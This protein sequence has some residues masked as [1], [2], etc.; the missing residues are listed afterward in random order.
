MRTGSRHESPGEAG[1]SHFIEH[2]LFKGTRKKSAKE[3]SEEI[4]LLG[5]Y[6]N[7]FT[8][9]EHTCLYA[10]VS[11]EHFEAA[12]ELMGE[13]LLEPLFDPVDIDRERQVVMEEIA[14]YE[15]NPE[16]VVHDLF[17]S[18]LWP[19][20]PLGRPVLGEPE[21][22]LGLGRDTLLDFFHRHYTPG[23]MVLSAVGRLDHG[24]VLAET[25]RILG[26]KGRVTSPWEFC[27]PAAASCQTQC[28]RD[29]EQV[30]ICMGFPTVPMEHPDVYPLLLLGEIMGGSASSRL[31]QRV[32]E[33]LGLVYSIYSSASHY[34]DGG[35]FL[36]YAG[37]SPGRWHEVRE[38]IT[39]EISSMRREGITP[40]ELRR[41]KAQVIGGLMLSLESTSSRMGRIGKTKLLLGRVVTTEESASR[42][43]AVSLEDVN[44]VAAEV[45]SPE[46][47][48]LAI[49]GPIE[50]TGG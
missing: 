47:E 15:D 2:L 24:E 3:I 49:L 10:K 36:A 23:R 30:H 6:M 40:R 33:D 20:H 16:G 19:S 45:L 14:T 7:A 34:S 43:E 28:Y 11:R 4:D 39:Q 5:G 46:H 44:R 50:G 21:T 22:L 35:T 9:K 29:T 13:M 38:L 42:V 26:G 18:A 48:A 12:L 32:R 41:A 31:F 8:A 37:S 1:A 27:P 25:S 17:Y